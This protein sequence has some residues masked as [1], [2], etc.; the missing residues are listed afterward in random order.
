VCVTLLFEKNNKSVKKV[1]NKFKEV[2]NTEKAIAKDI[3]IVCPFF[4]ISCK[5]VVASIPGRDVQLEV[6]CIANKFLIES[7]P[8][9]I[10]CCS[11]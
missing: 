8:D 4:R 2:I 5:Q 9:L 3:D 11:V 7:V 10:C 6:V 1:F